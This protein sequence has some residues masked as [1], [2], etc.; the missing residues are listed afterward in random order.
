M[1]RT[2]P[3]SSSSHLT[4]A[5]FQL[6][7]SMPRET[8]ITGKVGQVILPRYEAMKDPATGHV[9]E[10]EPRVEI[11]LSCE[12]QNNAT[13]INDYASIPTSATVPA[14]IRISLYPS[15]ARTGD[16]VGKEVK[17]LLTEALEY[18]TSC[19]ARTIT[20]DTA[21]MV[22]V[23]VKQDKAL[24]VTMSSQGVRM[25]KMKGKDPVYLLRG[26]FHAP[27]RCSDDG[28]TSLRAK[29]TICN[30]TMARNALIRSPFSGSNS[31][32]SQPRQCA[33]TNYVQR[34]WS[35]AAGFFASDIEGSEDRETTCN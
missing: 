11:T 10:A 30:S 5:S 31:E 13:I 16:E 27:V 28:L 20:I 6:D 17:S 12:L 8:H 24:E 29:T 21:D 15:D 22:V 23:G 26:E 35:T 1:G 14:T 34:N 18:A 2:K 7:S 19:V 25:V 33:G 4:S 32:I 9:K 3:F